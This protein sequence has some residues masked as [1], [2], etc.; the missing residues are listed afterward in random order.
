[1]DRSKRKIA[2]K[3][4]SICKKE[5]EERGAFPRARCSPFRDFRNAQVSSPR[6]RS[7]RSDRS[8]SARRGGNFEWPARDPAIYVRNRHRPPPPVLALAPFVRAYN[9]HL[10]IYLFIYHLLLFDVLSRCGATSSGLAYQSK[11]VLP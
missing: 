2:R 7:T 9:I 6:H 1:M 5:K 4:I 10:F 8:S 11:Q 3:I